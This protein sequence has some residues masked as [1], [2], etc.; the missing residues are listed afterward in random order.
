MS[1]KKWLT[2]G[3]SGAILA[4]LSEVEVKLS[5]PITY[6]VSYDNGEF[7]CSSCNYAVVRVCYL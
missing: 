7:L 3:G 6:I 2:I 5:K 1:A 4:D